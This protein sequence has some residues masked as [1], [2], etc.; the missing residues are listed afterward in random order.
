[1]IEPLIKWITKVDANHLS[2]WA[3]DVTKI[4]IQRQQKAIIWRLRLPG[5]GWSWTWQ[6][7]H[8]RL[9]RWYGPNDRNTIPWGPHEKD[10]F[11]MQ[12]AKHSDFKLELHPNAHRKQ[13]SC[14][15]FWYLQKGTCILCIF[16]RSPRPS[17]ASCL[18]PWQRR[19][20]GRT[21]A[22]KP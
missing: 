10:N 3:I 14:Y 7:H 6:I 12:I 19:R 9:S 13:Q 16:R 4:H 5:N 2:L 18:Q 17:P 21:R 15:Y 11:F 22:P 8:G 20:W 1:M